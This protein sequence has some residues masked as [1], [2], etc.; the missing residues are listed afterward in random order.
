MKIET[1][2]GS[3]APEDLCESIRAV[4]S[5]M[6]RQVA[7]NAGGVHLSTVNNL[8]TRRTPITESNR[9]AFVTLVRIARKRVQS[10]NDIR[11]I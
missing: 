4:T 5:M 8:L 7:A 1:L 9:D 11:E 3:L 6:D 10:L 2:T